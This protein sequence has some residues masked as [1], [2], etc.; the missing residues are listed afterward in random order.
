M[1]SWQRGFP[2]SSPT[3]HFVTREAPDAVVVL[4][5]TVSFV[6]VPPE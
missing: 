2:L 4:G 6:Y 5:K 1:L 3:C